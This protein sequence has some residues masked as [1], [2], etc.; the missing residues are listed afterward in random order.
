MDPEFNNLHKLAYETCSD[1]QT[2]PSLI[3]TTVPNGN[4]FQ[5]IVL[6]DNLVHKEYTCIIQSQ[7][8]FGSN[9][10]L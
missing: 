6:S 2:F 5:K 8:N 4:N 9:Y 1:S 3:S 7:N 10:I